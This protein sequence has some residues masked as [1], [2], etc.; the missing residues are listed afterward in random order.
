MSILRR[1]EREL[2]ER[3]RRFFAGTT[4]EQARGVL[5]I[6]RAILD[7]VA[8]RVEAVGRGRRVFPFSRL[9][10]HIAVPAP[11]ERPVYTLAFAEGDQL[12]ADI[13]EALREAG[14][15]PPAGLRVEVV[16]EEQPLAGGYRVVYHEKPAPQPA[17]APARP[18]TLTILRG[19]TSQRVYTLGTGRVNIGR[20]ADVLDG[21]ERL[22]RR[23]EI[24][25]ADSADPVAS[26][27][28][29]AHAHIR[30]DAASGEYRLYDDHSAYGTSLFRDGALLSVPAGAGPGVALRP[31]DEIYFGQA[32]ARFDV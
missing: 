2:D 32:R 14:A 17:R 15:E 31:G 5:E 20:L 6:H 26:T 11:E 21:R 13:R 23:N 27:V 1:V 3:I 16:L 12:A 18:A 28:S 29:R 24:A 22:V 10:V 4:G 9:S 7:E 8:E 25:F 19:E 30:Y